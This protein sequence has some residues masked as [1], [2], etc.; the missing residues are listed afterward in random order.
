MISELISES[1]LFKS[2][3]KDRISKRLSHAYLILGE[4]K[5]TRK[6]FVNQISLYLMCE[7]GGCMECKTC[8]KVMARTHF[9]L[10]FLNEDGKLKTDDLNQL[11]DYVYIKP[12]EAEY[13]L[14]FIDNADGLSD[15]IQNKLLKLYEEPPESVI[16]FMLAR[17][18]AGI[19]RTIKSRAKTLYLPIFSS[20]QIYLELLE[21]GVEESVAKAAAII[22]G[23]Q[24]DRAYLFSNQEG[25]LEMYN[26]CVDLLMNLKKSQDVTAY[27][28]SKLFE[29][30]KIDVTLD[31]FQIIFKDV[32]VYI[33][34]SNCEYATIGR[35][36]DIKDI[37]DGF[38]EGGVALAILSI[39]KAKMMLK[40]NVS[41]LSVAE[42]L[43]LQILEDKYK[44]KM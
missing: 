30:D 22:S 37:A 21:Q 34:K 31:Y 7:N 4:D 19:L 10:I 26:S 32:L 33:S 41:S 44:S 35:E 39:V 13:K 24:F 3:V 40:A 42:S 17:G 23:G 18:E 20:K 5:E 29:K 1:Q 2:L 16:I 8:A 11:I 36:C 15:N 6:A 27:I 38:N 43:M 28:G 14:V 12:A 25:Y 9:D